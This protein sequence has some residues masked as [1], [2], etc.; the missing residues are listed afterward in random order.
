MKRLFTLIE[1]LVVIAIIA[2]LASILLPALSMA[3]EKGYNSQC[4]SNIRQMGMAITMYANEWDEYFSPYDNKIVGVLP[5][6]TFWINLYKPYHGGDDAARLCPATKVSASD[7]LTAGW[8]RAKV[9]WG[10]GWGTNYGSYALN[11][12]IHNGTTANPG[13]GSYWCSFRKMTDPTIIPFFGDANWV[14]AW[15][16]N[17]D[18]PPP[19]YWDGSQPSQGGGSSMGRFCVDRHWRGINIVC[20]DISVKR[21]RL[22]E[23]WSKFKWH[24]TYTPVTVSYY[25]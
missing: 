14:D 8:G 2:I 16:G 20:A 10:P 23:L 9:A 12:W 7:Q 22:N 6:E 11:S 21:A 5:N 18:A 19:S 4:Q 13:T 24:S 3:K 15:P 17:G 25:P 1:L